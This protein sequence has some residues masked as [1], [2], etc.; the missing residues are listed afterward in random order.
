MIGVGI[1]GYGYW[2]P[3]LVRNLSEIPGCR[4]IGISDLRPERLA[5][6]RARYPSAKITAECQDLFDDRRIDLIVVATPV[7]SHFRLALAALAAGKHVLVE[8]PFTTTS[9]DAERLIEE[10]A[11]RKL[12]LA[13][14]HTFVYTP[15]VRKIREIVAAGGLGDVRYYDSVRVNLGLFQHDV[16][17]IWDLAVHD[18]SILDYVLPMRPVAVTA[19]GLSHVPGEPENIAYLT[20]LFEENLIAHVHVNWL[21]PLK[22]RKT[23]I[24]GSQQ[25]IVYDDLE[26]SEKV[27]VYDK[28]ITVTEQ[29]AAA[30]NGK[31]QLLVGYRAGDMWAPQIEVTEALGI[32]LRHLMTC[33]ERGE[34]PQSDGIAGLRIV[35]LL[36]AATASMRARGRVIELDSTRWAA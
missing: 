1:I 13:V 18:L 24:G 10:A 31:Y 7:S 12:M 2:G 8:K 5:L 30:A 23:L 15:A 6:A 33:I 9:E 19:T 3:N 14:D 27:K 16:N 32:E 20:L 34:T 28:G 36:E 35:G 17:V 11:R 4:V 21:A 29:G 22:L 25:M 26:P